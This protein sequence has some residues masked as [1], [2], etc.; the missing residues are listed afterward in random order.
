MCKAWWLPNDATN[1]LVEGFYQTNTSVVPIYLPGEM[2]LIQA[3]A[4]ARSG[5]LTQ[6]VALVD[7]VRTKTAADDVYGLGASLPAYSGGT[8]HASV[9]DEIYR[10]RRIELY[11]MGLANED[12]KRFNRPDT[13]YSRAYYPYPNVERDNNTNTPANPVN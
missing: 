5:N 7:Q 11:L 4:N 12:T 2:L 8:D 6:A 10:N 9:L 13:E 1:F 3:E